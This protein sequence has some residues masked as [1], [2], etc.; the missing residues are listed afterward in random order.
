MHSLL[1][2]ALAT[3]AVVLAIAPELHAELRGHGGP[4]RALAVSPSSERA[5]SGSFDQSAILWDLRRNAALSVLRFHEGSVNAVAILPGGAFATGGEDGRIAVWEVGRD[6][7]VR[8]F[9][10]HTA[11]VVALSVSP[12]RRAIFSASWDG[13]AGL[14]NLA[15][16]S[17]AKLEGHTG[18]V[19]AVAFTGTGQPVSA[20]Y[21]GT[22]RIWPEGGDGTPT[23]AQLGGPISALA[24]TSGGGIVA[25][26]ADGVVRLL[27]LDG[28]KRGET[29]LRAGPVAALAYSG[30]ADRLAV[31]T[32]G[33]AV[34]V[35]DATL[36]PT[37]MRLAVPRPPVWSA[38]F[39]A[40]G[41]ELLTGGGDGVV[42]R[43]D[44]GSGDEIGPI[45]LAS[46][47]DLPDI[48]GHERGRRAFEACAACHTLTP[49]GGNRAGPSLFGVIGRRIGTLPGYPYSEA[50]K[51]GDIV[52]TAETIG[53]LF[54]VGPSRYTPG[55]KMPE[56]I[57]AEGDREALVRFIEA[58][59]RVPR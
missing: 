42:R 38:A 54:E 18:P 45:A 23:V 26:G 51:K 47:N 43:W 58:A 14:S 50:L 16:G 5:V 25:G 7:P 22:V 20:G 37:A 10:P 1:A 57:V 32:L 15:T 41:R 19:N 46:R 9:H 59:T 12:D 4:V 24:V 17:T 55:T 21:D 44:L 8:A 33:G 3:I 53:K 27:D 29:E 11:P 13:T 48:P 2:R 28:S 36:V 49:D 56:Q 30:E 52:W 6:A 34:V 40:G 35:L 39:M 31:A